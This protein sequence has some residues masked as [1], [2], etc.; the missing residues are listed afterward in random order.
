MEA[1]SPPP[2]PRDIKKKDEQSTVGQ[3]AKVSKV[4]QHK[5]KQV[6]AV[7][8]AI[9]AGKLPMETIAKVSAD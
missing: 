8:K 3:I 7:A 1:D 5:G 4:S 2:F 9:K 6:V